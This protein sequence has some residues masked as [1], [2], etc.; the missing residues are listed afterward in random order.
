MGIYFEL[1]NGL[2]VEIERNDVRNESDLTTLMTWHRALT[3]EVID[4]AEMARSFKDGG[5]EDRDLCYKLG[6]FRVAQKW[7]SRRMAELGR[8]TEDMNDRE[9]RQAKEITRLLGINKMQA[10]ELL[11][12]RGPQ[13]V[14][15]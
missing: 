9:A 13:A 11:A 12:L 15:A 3:L 4:M 5:V 7:V 8:K 14:A 10:D 2:E 6:T 1:E